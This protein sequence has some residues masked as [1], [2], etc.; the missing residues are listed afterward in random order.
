MRDVE[1][2][3]LAAV[4]LMAPHLPTWMGIGASLLALYEAWKAGR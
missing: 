1:F 2:W 3:L 4:M